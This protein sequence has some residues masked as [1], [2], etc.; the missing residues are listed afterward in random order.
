MDLDKA[1]KER[2]SVRRYKTKKPDYEKILQAIQAAINGPLAGNIPTLKFILVS[3]KEKIQ[4]LAEAAEQ[5]FVATAHYV[6]A[7]CSNKTNCIRSYEEKGEI[8]FRQQAGAA[9]ENFLLKITDLKLSTCWVG[10]FSEKM[11]KRILKIPDNIILEAFF[12]IGYELGHA[13]KKAKQSI[14]SVLYFETWG[15]EYMRPIRKPEAL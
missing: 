4:Q 14:E 8:Y 13:Q 12:P 7:I 3:D 6:V 10:A 5:D 11:V 1:I 9:I 2:H 15:N